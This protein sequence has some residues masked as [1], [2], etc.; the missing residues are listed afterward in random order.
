MHD[1]GK[2][3]SDLRLR[4]DEGLKYILSRILA[5]AGPVTRFQGQLNHMLLSKYSS[6]L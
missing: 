2:K 5:W 6:R 3:E 1:F 4:M